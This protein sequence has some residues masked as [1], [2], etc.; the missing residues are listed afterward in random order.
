MPALVD[1]DGWSKTG[2]AASSPA[3]TSCRSVAADE[4]GKGKAGGVGARL[5]L[6]RFLAGSEL[7]YEALGVLDMV[8]KADQTILGDAEFRGLR[9]A[10]RAM[11]GR[12][13]DAQADFSSPVL[14]DDPASAPSGAATSPKSLGD[15]AGARQQFAAG[16]RAMPLFSEKWRG[17]FRRGRRGGGAGRRRPAHRAQRNRPCRRPEDRSRRRHTAEAGAGAAVWRRKA[18]RTPP[19]RSTIRWRR[20]L[21]RAFRPRDAARGADPPAAGQDEARRRGAALDSLRFRWRGD[22]TELETVRTLGRLY[23]AQGQY[24]RRWRRCAP[25]TAACPICP[26]PSPSRRSFQHLQDLFLNGGADGMQPI[27]ALALFY[28]FKDLTPIGADGDQMV[29]KLSHRLV[30]VD[31]LDQAAELLKYQVDNRLDGVPK[32]EVSTD[33]AMIDLMD[34]K[35][36][37]ALSALNNSRTTLLPTVLNARRRLIEARAHMALG[38]YDNALELAA[39]RQDAGGVGHPRRD[40]LAAEE[41]AAGRR[42]VRSAAGRPLEEPRAADRRRTGPPG[43]RGHRLQPR[44]RRQIPGAPARRI[45]ASWRTRAR[46][47]TW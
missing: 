39:G 31:L 21:R 27:Q 12:Y 33:L 41:L 28:D 6:A 32:A 29:R 10:A 17:R 1:F 14:A 5:A 40:R 15:H 26:P 45:T 11:A 37:D 13:K 19:C 8:A 34:K 7:S 4:E 25:P 42:P 36:E 22:A 46:R 9:G 38:R 23:L 47:P 18:S 43:A 24:R 3:T 35:P 16:R 2:G 20:S 44:R 30:D